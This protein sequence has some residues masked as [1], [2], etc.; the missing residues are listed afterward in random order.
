MKKTLSLKP[1]LSSVVFIFSLL[2]VGQSQASLIYSE[3]FESDGLGSRYSAAGAG[4]GGGGCCQVWQLNSLDGGNES[5]V[6]VGFE[7]N[8][9]WAA[10][11]LNDSNLPSGFS[12]TTPRSLILNNIDVS[13][14]MNLQVDVMLA[15][16]QNHES[17]DFF[18]VFILDN[19]SNTKTILEEFTSPANSSP[20]TGSVSNSNLGLTFSNFNYL[21]SNGFSNVSIGFEAWNTANN[22]VLG[23]DNIR[24]SGDQQRVGNVPEPSMLG[25]L[26]IGLFMGMLGR[27]RS[28]K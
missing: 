3:T 15:G 9:F 25:L 19:D 2:S 11:D 13:N 8:D 7:G 22:E 16:S 18:R 28:K 10:S 6:L 12:A 5:D 20:L 14:Y 27:R 26:G 21:L 24:V 1:V 4:N 23:I 17:S